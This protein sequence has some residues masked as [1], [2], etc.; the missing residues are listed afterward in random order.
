MDQSIFGMALRFSS[1][2]PRELTHI[3][4]TALARSAQRTGFYVQS[5]DALALGGVLTIL[6]GMTAS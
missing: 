2:Q 5:S 4:L 1:N 3:S 6:T